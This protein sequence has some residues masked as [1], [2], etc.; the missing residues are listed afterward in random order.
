[1]SSGS[2]TDT[3]RQMD[4]H[5]KANRKCL[6][7]CKHAYELAKAYVHVRMCGCAH[8]HGQKGVGAYLWAR[9]DYVCMCART[10]VQTGRMYF[11]FL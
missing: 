6:R 10:G 4:E 1:M 11:H 3:L 7:L 5:D 2:H 9:L 8:V